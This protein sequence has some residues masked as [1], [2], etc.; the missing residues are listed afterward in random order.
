MTDPGRAV[1]DE[2]SFTVRRSIHI[3]AAPEAVWRAV[4]EPELISRWF[5][6]AELDGRGPG[7]AGTLSWPGNPPIPFRV[8]AV[9][10]PRSISYRWSN[11]DAASSTVDEA[12][13]TV[14]TFTLEPVD[15]GTRLTVVETGFETTSDPTLTM[16]QHRQGWDSELDELVELVTR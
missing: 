16:E 15:G 3:A 8:E 5:G 4:T 1:V 12:R 10:A 11:D 2:Q 13:S 7:A 14:F 6:A 9:D